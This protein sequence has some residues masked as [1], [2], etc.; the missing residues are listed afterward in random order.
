MGINEDSVEKWNFLS[1]ARDDK[2]SNNGTTLR[3]EFEVS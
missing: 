2:E 1:P 3:K